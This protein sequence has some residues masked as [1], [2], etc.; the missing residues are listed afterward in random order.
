MTE[1]S[2]SVDAV[3]S[4]L[5]DHVRERRRQRV[6]TQLL[7]QGAP[8]AFEDPA[9]F[10]EVEAVLQRAT[11]AGDAEALL[12]PELLG[13]PHTWRL[14]T[15]LR[16]QSHRTA[17]LAS[18]V[19]FLKRRVILPLIRWLF[20]YSRDNFERQR[21]VNRVLFACVQELAAE[22]ARLRQEVGR[23]SSR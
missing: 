17:G 22:T 23:L 4:E 19:F 2:V 21:R 9:V 18:V 16:Y 12:L 13:D 11:E 5:Q 10:D 1:S 7:R 14:D 8:T 15:A 20:E 6:R 3:M